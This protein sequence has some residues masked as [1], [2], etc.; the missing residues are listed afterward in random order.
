MPL[1]A[2]AD[3]PCLCDIAVYENRLRRGRRSCYL[4]DSILDSFADVVAVAVLAV[5]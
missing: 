4:K 2:V 5:A 1:E 3:A